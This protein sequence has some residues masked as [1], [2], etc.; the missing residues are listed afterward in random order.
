MEAAGLSILLIVSIFATLLSMCTGFYLDLLTYNLESSNNET[1][2]IQFLSNYDKEVQKLL[3]ESTVAE[4]NYY[5]NLTDEN[6]KTNSA[7]SLKVSYTFHISMIIF[8]TT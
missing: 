1:E 7:K 2:A 4:W 6:E 8:Y 5:T 3:T